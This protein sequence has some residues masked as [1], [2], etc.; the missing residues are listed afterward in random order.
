MMIIATTTKIMIR[1]VTPIPS[2]PPDGLEIIP[3][4][5]LAPAFP[6]P[7]PSGVRSSSPFFVEK[8][9]QIT[10]WSFNETIVVEQVN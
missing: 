1:I 3:Q 2:S 6:T 5:I 4:A 7:S 9:E 8:E 10:F